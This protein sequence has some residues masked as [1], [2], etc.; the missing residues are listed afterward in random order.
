[1]THSLRMTEE[2]ER[3]EKRSGTILQLGEGLTAWGLW[4]FTLDTYLKGPGQCC[5]ATVKREQRESAFSSLSQRATPAHL[6]LCQTHTPKPV[7]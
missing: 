4:A 5:L 3:G 6:S 1:M 7:M 2:R